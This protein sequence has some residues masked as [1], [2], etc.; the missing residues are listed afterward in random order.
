M[1]NEMISVVDK[2]MKN[3]KGSII[4]KYDKKHNMLRANYTSNKRKVNVYDITYTDLIKSLGVALKNELTYKNMDFKRCN[5]LYIGDITE[6]LYMLDSEIRFV[7]GFGNIHL[8]T[9]CKDGGNKFVCN[10]SSFKTAFRK[11][12]KL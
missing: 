7:Y 11:S 5:D 12:L 10:L 6:K 2:C 9:A 4:I 8:M 3:E 1:L